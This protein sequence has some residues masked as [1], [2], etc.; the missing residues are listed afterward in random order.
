MNHHHHLLV[1]LYAKL[2]LSS[3]CNCLLTLVSVTNVRR[4]DIAATK[5]S[6]FRQ[7]KADSSPLYPPF[8]DPVQQRATKNC[9]IIIVKINTS[10]HIL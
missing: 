8:R 2:K 6:F 9:P 4:A 5:A 1:V 3:L 10:I 7:K